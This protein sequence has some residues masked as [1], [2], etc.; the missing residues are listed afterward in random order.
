MLLKF[1][2]AIASIFSCVLRTLSDQWSHYRL[3]LPTCPWS[4]G[5]TKCRHLSVYHF[6]KH[7]TVIY[8][9][10]YAFWIELRTLFLNEDRT[11]AY[12]LV[13]YATA[14]ETL[15]RLHSWNEIIQMF[16][17]HW[18][19]REKNVLSNNRKTTHSWSTYCF[20][21]PIECILNILRQHI[22]KRHI[23]VCISNA[24]FSNHPS[25][26][27]KQCKGRFMR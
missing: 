21:C 9:N 8:I 2:I 12:P 23:V 27:I 7:S 16:C 1:A 11:F 10:K 26:I 20:F 14:L 15:V 13:P 18:D 24:S 5:G 3:H 17:T 25:V 4:G 6:S 22:Q 19:G